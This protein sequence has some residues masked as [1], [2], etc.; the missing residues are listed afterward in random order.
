MKKLEE[1][2]YVERKKDGKDA[3]KKRVYVTT[4][5]RA[6]EEEFHQIFRDLNR[7]LAKDFTEDEKGLMKKLLVG[8]SNNII[9]DQ[10]IITKTKTG[11]I[12]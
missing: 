12:S 7:L 11:E 4:K 1:E 10:S 9:Q 5:S 2:G 3:R 8:M 6:F